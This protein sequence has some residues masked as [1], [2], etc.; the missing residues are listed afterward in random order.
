MR[1]QSKL[2]TIPSL[3]SITKMF[4][5]CVC[6]CLY[7][8]MLPSGKG[9]EILL[10]YYWSFSPMWALEFEHSRLGGKHLCPLSQFTNLQHCHHHDFA[11]GEQ[12]ELS[13]CPMMPPFL[14]LSPGLGPSSP[15]SMSQGSRTPFTDGCPHSFSQHPFT[16]KPHHLG[17]SWALDTEEK[18]RCGA[19]LLVSSMGTVRK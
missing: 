1:R 5:Y 14:L 19:Y 17:V 16:V 12:S 6:M 8:H 11:P 18:L 2:T 3:Y 15:E 4:I 7:T 10:D 9:K 13:G